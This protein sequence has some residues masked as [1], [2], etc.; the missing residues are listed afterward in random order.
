MMTKKDFETIACAIR[1]LNSNC[2][3]WKGCANSDDEERLL[4]IAQRIAA[5]LEGSNPRFDRARFMNRCTEQFT[6]TDEEIAA[7]KL[8]AFPDE[9]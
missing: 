9:A 2:L 3:V 7:W 1:D 5:A 6:S 4:M 8:E